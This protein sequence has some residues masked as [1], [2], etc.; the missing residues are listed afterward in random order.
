M[1]IRSER[2]KS[3]IEQSKLSYVELEKLTGIKKS[4]L[5]RYASGVTSK[6]PLEVIEK[7]S[8]VFHVS[9]QYLMGW[10]EEEKKND[11]QADIILRM[12]SDSDF[13]SAVNSLYKLDKEQLQSINQMLHTL[14]K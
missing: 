14:F 10:E 6:I 7:L 3:L 13:M 11:I 5:Q 8:K 9:Q 4:S 2:I 12:R 1:S